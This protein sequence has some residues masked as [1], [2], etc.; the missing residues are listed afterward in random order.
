[1]QVGGFVRFFC[2]CCCKSCLAAYVLCMLSLF[3]EI[4]MEE[5]VRA[6]SST[7]VPVCLAFMKGSQSELLRGKLQLTYPV[8][9][10]LL[11]LL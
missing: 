6:A 10:N 8:E 4:K 11:C 7:S 9:K 2:C 1:M 5:F 3:W